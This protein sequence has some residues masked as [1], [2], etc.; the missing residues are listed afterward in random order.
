MANYFT[1]VLRG[2]RLG[3]YG[4]WLLVIVLLIIVSGYWRRETGCIGI[5]GV[6]ILN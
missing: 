4:Y 5:I 2:Q 6:L 3:H 1:L